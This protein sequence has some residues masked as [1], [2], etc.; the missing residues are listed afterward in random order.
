MGIDVGRGG[1]SLA[2]VVKNPEECDERCIP[3]PRELRCGVEGTEYKLSVCLEL[4]GVPPEE[5]QLQMQLEWLVPQ[6]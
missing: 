2:E 1:A 4:R 3:T 5:E 6:K